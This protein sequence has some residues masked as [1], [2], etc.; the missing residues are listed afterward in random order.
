MSTEI[1]HNL[2]KP[3]PEKMAIEQVK[4]IYDYTK[5]HI[6]LYSTLLTGLVALVTVIRRQGF[7]EQYRTV[8]FIIIIVLLIGG[9][10]GA[11][12]ASRIVYGPWEEKYFV[13]EDSR[14]WEKRWLWPKQFRCKSWWS[15]AD[16]SLMVEHYAFW[17]ALLIAIVRFSR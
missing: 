7:G 3:R 17:L 15:W 10:A 6:G 14:F 5:F 12:A 4:Q 13:I 9:I 11:L 2:D 1:E 8:L 16:V